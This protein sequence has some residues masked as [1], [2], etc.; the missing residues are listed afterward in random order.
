MLLVAIVAFGVLCVADWVLIEDF[1]FW[2][3]TGTDPN[4]MLPLLAVAV[5]GYLGVTRPAE[6]AAGVDSAAT[7]EGVD[8]GDPTLPAPGVIPEPEPVAAF[9]PEPEGSRNR[10]LVGAGVAT[11]AVAPGAGPPSTRSWWEKVDSR[12]AA[13]VAAAVASIG[14]VLVGVA[15]MAAATVNRTADPSAH[16][17]GQRSPERGR[18]PGARIRA[19]R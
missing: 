1:G 2:G 4:S 18:Q 11:S 3:G 8:A 5:T 9:S 17:S 13:R 6:A 7:A 15:P 14:I 16:R 10:E 12:Y 19:H